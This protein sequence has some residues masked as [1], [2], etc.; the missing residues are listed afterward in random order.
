M[1]V[2]HGIGSRA[3]LPLPF[4]IVALGA[5]TILV[6]SFILL[7]M[8]W[9]KSSFG[10]GAGRRVLGRGWQV[11]ARV[12]EVCLRVAGLAIFVIVL[13]AA[14]G[15]HA[16]PAIN[17][18][19]VVVYIAFWVGLQVVS[20]ILGDVW[21][22]LSPFE[23]ISLVAVRL[24]RRIAPAA[25]DSV[26]SER[27][28]AAAGPWIGAV[29]LLGFAWIE[30]ISVT[31]DD[32]RVLGWAIVTYSVI[33]LAG[34][35]V[36]GR[37][38]LRGADGFAAYFSMLGA[39]GIF[40][41][42]ESGRDEPRRL[43]LRAPLRGLAGLELTPAQVAVVLIALGSTTYD[44]FSG[45]QL[46]ADTVGNPTELSGVLVGSL[47][48][49][50]TIGIVSLAYII[51]TR[52]A[53]RS[54]DSDH[55]DVVLRYAHS[56]IPIAAAYTVAHYFSLLVFEAQQ[57]IPLAS[58]PFGF[59]FDFFGT[60]HY[61]LNFTYVS[62]TVIAVVQVAAIVIGHIAGV[63]VAHDRALGDAGRTAAIKSQ[64]PLL[65]VMLAYTIGGMLILMNAE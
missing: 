33:M 65:V 35:A 45:T 43:C 18:T 60:A 30:L 4:W 48:L 47:G 3:D 27:P 21:R 26:P 17:V 51:A 59:G 44:G 14:L 15:G 9:T 5:A 1:I 54:L 61:G 49:V 10:D 7:G 56:L 50:V 28:G 31:P 20:A 2:A 37:G 52:E 25:A 41:R 8:L 57:L 32:V 12:A 23:T 24:R 58:D 19:P 64:I 42:D 38:W 16:N 6:A 63:F 40:C 34:A 55:G 53:A 36:W 39:M 11:A 29:L 62:A 22:W 46:W 13:V